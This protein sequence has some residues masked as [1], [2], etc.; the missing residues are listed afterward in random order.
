MITIIPALSLLVVVI[1]WFVNNWLVRR[2]EITIK[3]SQYRINT[4]RSFIALS[5]TLNF[6]QANFNPKEMMDVQVEFNIF[7][8]QD[9][10]N[11]INELIQFL[12]QKQL[13]EASKKLPILTNLVRNRLRKELGLPNVT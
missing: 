5:K 11:L 3:R 4:L 1:G 10:I 2:H 12:S 7:G 9:E 8:Y 6:D 13:E